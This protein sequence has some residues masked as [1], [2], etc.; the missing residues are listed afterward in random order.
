MDALLADHDFDVLLATSKHNVQYLLGGYRYFFFAN[1]DAIGLSRYLPVVGYLRDR[2]EDSFYVGCGNEDW[3]T[4][5]FPI[6]ISD[7]RNVSWSSVDSARSAAAALRER[8]LG[9]ATIGVEMAFIPAD[10]FMV[11]RAELPQ[12]R[13]VDAHLAL[14]ALRAVK[15]PAEL[16]LVRHASEMIVAS[17]LATFDQVRPGQTKAE[18]V[19]RF[20][21]EQTS[22]GLVYDY[23]LVTAGPDLNR[24]PSDAPWLPGTVLSLDSGGM[25]RGY[26]GDLARMAVHGQPTDLMLELMDEVEAVQQAAREPVAAGNKGAAI[27][28]AAVARLEASPHRDVLRFVAHGMGLITH[29]VP[30]LTATGP[31]P[32]PADHAD[33]PLQAGNVLSIETWTEHPLVGFV[34]LEDTLIVTEEGWE[35]PGDKG[36]GYNI[37]G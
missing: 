21:L 12:A 3:G 2:P 36:R 29:E 1:M 25:Y 5:T 24:A 15:T 10:A 26:I 23:C 20:R 6:G 27:F 30:R 7:I 34:K 32:Y 4:D 17:M 28:E 18:I 33:R 8:G 37:I 14:E 13:F 16:E 31:V 9:A 22:R 35:A 11:L 19:E